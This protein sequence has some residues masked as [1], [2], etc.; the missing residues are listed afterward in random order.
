[1]ELDVVSAVLVVLAEDSVALQ[2]PIAVELDIV[3]LAFLG[4]QDSVALQNAVAVKLDVV[5][6]GALVLTEDAIALLLLLR[7]ADPPSGLDARVW[8]ASSVQLDGWITPNLP[9]DF[10]PKPI[11]RAILGPWVG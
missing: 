9:T 2:H 7:H 3:T 6:A 11:G 5:L 1:V 10:F 4:P 8:R